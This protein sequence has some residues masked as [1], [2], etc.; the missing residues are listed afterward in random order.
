MKPKLLEQV[1]IRARYKHYSLHTERAYIYWIRRYILFH[2]KRHP[3]ELGGPDIARFLGHASVNTTMIYTHVL[4]KGGKGVVSPAD[5]MA[6]LV[7][8]ATAVEYFAVGA[9]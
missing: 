3:S 6:N 8:K 7:L 4:N 5:N 9:V 2:H 1:R